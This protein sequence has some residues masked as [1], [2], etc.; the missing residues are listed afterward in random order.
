MKEIILAR[1]NP[2]IFVFLLLLSGNLYS[3]TGIPEEL[4]SRPIQDQLDWLE[5]RTRIYD[6]F[7]AIREDMF[8]KIKNNVSDSLRA[9]DKKIAELTRRA[10]SLNRQIDSL[11]NTL[12]TTKTSLDDMTDTKNSINI[13]GMNVNK[14]TYNSIVWTIIAGLI[15]LL[16][17]GFVVFRRNQALTLSTQ[18]E[19]KDLK[20]EFEE[21]RKTTRLAREK[22]TM[23]HF[24]EIKKLRGG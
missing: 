19:L 9:D 14:I 23:D 13:L 6:N 21:Y 24:N 1:F 17:L 15:V 5:N 8:Q 2:V 3:Q 16:L 10:S 4:N 12:Q 7:R 20:D 11:E 18:K 22:M